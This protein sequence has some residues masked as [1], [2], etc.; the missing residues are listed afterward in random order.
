MQFLASTWQQY[1]VSV[2]GGPPDRWN[3]ADSIFTAARYLKANDGPRE[4]QRAIFAYNHSTEYV[5]EVLGW[6]EH[7]EREAKALQ[8]PAAT[9]A[10]GRALAFAFAAR[11]TR[12][13]ACGMCGAARARRDM[14]APG[15]CRPPIAPPA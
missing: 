2:S 6:A 8:A 13:A 9:G 7:Y 4:L 11:G 15:S 12:H 1:G 3:A 5:A 14:T 10:A